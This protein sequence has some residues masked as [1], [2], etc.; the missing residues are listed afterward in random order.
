MSAVVNTSIAFR[1]ISPHTPL[2]K[3]PQQL[4]QLFDPGLADHRRAHTKQNVRHQLSFEPIGYANPANEPLV[5]NCFSNGQSG[6]EM[7]AGA[8]GGDQ[9]G[10][11]FATIALQA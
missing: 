4:H 3:Q 7:A 11:F 2:P 8:A 5:F 9:S 1:R 10:H 6:E